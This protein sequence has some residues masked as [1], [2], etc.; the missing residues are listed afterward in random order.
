DALKQDATYAVRS[1]LRRPA[2]TVT[3]ILV[4]AIGVGANAAVLSV[5]DHIFLRPPAV[6]RAPDQLKRIVIAAQHG[7]A[8]TNFQVR[9]SLPEARI[10]DSTIS[11]A[12]PSTI[13]YRH[14][15]PIAS[16][17]GLRRDVMSAWV[18][19]TYFSVLGV[20]LYAGTDFGP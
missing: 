3:A 14:K 19:P 1:L 17:G 15:V 7:D 9:F 16:S 13:F 20:P 5:V 11:T 6:V 8:S 10:I 18:T 2:F 4:L 12:F